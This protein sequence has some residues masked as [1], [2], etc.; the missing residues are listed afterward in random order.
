MNISELAG[1]YS[2]ALFELAV[3]HRTQDKVFSDLRALQTIFS[4]DDGIKN[5][6]AN[7]AVGAEDRTR[8]IDAALKD[9][10]VSKEAYSL[11]LLLAQKNRLAL[12]PEIVKTFEAVADA[13]NGVCRGSVRSATML[14][15]AERQH[16][17]STVEKVLRKKVIM[18]Y[19]VDPSV[20]GGLVANV[21]S[22]TF[23]DS[24]A[25]HLRRIGDELKRRTV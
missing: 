22:Y 17:E 4:T 21:G 24:I 9:K 12:F 6:F 10:G 19:A 23:D 13:A 14:G 18:T 1:R 8:V 25:S 20:I 7:P 3:D 11:C 2:R 15:Q 5:F 16:I